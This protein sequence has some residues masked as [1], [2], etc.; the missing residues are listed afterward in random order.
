VIGF[1]RREPGAAKALAA[2]SGRWRRTLAVLPARRAG[3]RR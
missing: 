3:K 2:R 1:A